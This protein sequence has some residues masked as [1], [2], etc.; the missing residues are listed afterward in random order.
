MSFVLDAS[1]TVVWAMPD[2][3]DPAAEYALDVTTRHGA[4]V[5]S[6]WWYEIRNILIVNERRGR[7]TP[8]KTARFMSELT[9]FD[10]RVLPAEWHRDLQALARLYQLTVYDA[11]YLDL[12]M[13]NNLP[14]ATLDRAL[15]SAAIA[16][17][18]P[19]LAP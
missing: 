19:L 18:V 13:R 15:K 2:E 5:P 17:G 3:T 7:I 16:A 1:V 4:Y 12:A 8:A 10:I 6:I 9:G 11:A 14:L